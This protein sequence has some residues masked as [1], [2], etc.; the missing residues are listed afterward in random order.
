MPEQVKT[1]LNKVVEFWNKWTTKQKTIIISAFA[2][3][4][5]AVAVIVF[6]L[7]RTKYTELYRFNTVEGA[8]SAVQTLKNGGITAKLDSDNLT[9]LVDENK[10][11]DA[12]VAVSSASIEEEGFSIDKMLDTSLTTTNG[13]RLLRQFLR[14][15][16]D[17]EKQI[18]N[19]K[20]VEDASVTFLGKDTSNSILAKNQVIKVTCFITT[21]KQFDED[22]ASAI[23]SLC[24]AGVG[25]QDT[26]Y[27]TVV[28]QTG[29]IL[30][31]GPEKEDE[32]SI[33]F[34]DKFQILNM[35]E[36]KYKENVEGTLIRAGY[37]EVECGLHLETNFDKI[38]KVFN[39]VIPINGEDYGVL[40]EY[41]ETNSQ[42]SSGNGDVVGTDSND[43]TDYYLQEST[44]GN[45]SSSTQDSYYEPSRSVTTTLYDTGTVNADLSSISV[46]GTRV[47]T[48]TKRELE[49]LGLLDD[50]T[51]EEYNIRNSGTFEEESD[52]DMITLISKA[53]GIPE[54]NVIFKSY[55]TRQYVEE[56]KQ[57][58]DVTTIVQVAL[59]ALLL[60]ILLFVILRSMKPVEVTEV[61][62]ELSIEQLLATTKENQGLEEVEFSDGSETRKM[63]EKFFD[64]NPEAVAQLLRNWLNED[65]M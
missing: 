40:V 38:T 59:A 36:S 12:I 58:V 25:N 54:E 4:V 60:L 27:I 32:N 1:I 65:W 8:S 30:Y 63:I 31:D 24:A 55:V 26:E 39:E 33:D 15:E 17:M 48:Q 14:A 62:P 28:D 34:T 57:A 53:T 10:Y 22:E 20:G 41:H 43:D 19:F 56:E 61:E 13:E 49:V 50:M 44:G 51:F 52:P 16:S 46:I 7:S 37:F 29:K 11:V 45:S 18:K 21:N 2:G 6:L 3:V 5:V 35:L 23:A 64:E 47:V 9:V 42:G